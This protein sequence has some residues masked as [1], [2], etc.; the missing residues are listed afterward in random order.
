VHRAVSPVDRLV[1]NVSLVKPQRVNSSTTPIKEVK[2]RP[3]S[4]PESFGLLGREAW[5]SHADSVYTVT[6]V[7][8]TA[9]WVSALPSQEAL[10][11]LLRISCHGSRS[12][13]EAH[14]RVRIE[15]HDAS[16]TKE[17]KPEG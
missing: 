15:P 12:W 14:G 4:V 6:W 3:D 1:D 10:E 7:Y 16:V 8:P 5:A 17:W 2:H 13:P 9:E 11:G